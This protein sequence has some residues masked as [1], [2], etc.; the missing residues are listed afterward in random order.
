MM[1]LPFL[2]F[3]TGYW[4]GEIVWLNVVGCHEE[5]VNIKIATLRHYFVCVVKCP[6]LDGINGIRVV[7]RILMV[8][9]T[10]NVLLEQGVSISLH[11][12]FSFNPV[13]GRKTNIL[14]F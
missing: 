12:F 8:T 13:R 2:S 5:G 10:M 7:G 6:T 11:T 14:I 4:R 3:F 1:R 9:C